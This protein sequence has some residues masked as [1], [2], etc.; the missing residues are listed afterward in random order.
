M[1]WTLTRDTQIR[2]ELRKIEKYLGMTA[3]EIM[4]ETMRNTDIFRQHRQNVGHGVN[5]NEKDRDTSDQ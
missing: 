1:Q 3:E 5:G 4:D 2:D